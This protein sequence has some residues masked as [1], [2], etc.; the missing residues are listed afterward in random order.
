MPQ[1]FLQNSIPTFNLRKAV[2]RNICRYHKESSLTL[3]DLEIETHLE[4]LKSSTSSGVVLTPDLVALQSEV[5]ALRK[6]LVDATPYL[7]SYDQGKYEQVTR[8]PTLIESDINSNMGR[9]HI[10]NQRTG[11]ILVPTACSEVEILLQ[12]QTSHPCCPGK[13]SIRHRSEASGIV[14]QFHFVYFSVNPNVNTHNLL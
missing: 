8:L 6:D 2:C 3:S 12:A 4:I 1:I 5:V 14:S 11:R 13:Q 9:H 10:A 7:P